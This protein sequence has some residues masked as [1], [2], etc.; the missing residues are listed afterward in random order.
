MLR[1]FV[2]QIIQCVFYFLYVC[3]HQT[4]LLKNAYKAACPIF[5]TLSST[6]YEIIK[7]KYPYATDS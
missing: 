4:S 1:H 6:I 7:K 2:N 5:G 3:F